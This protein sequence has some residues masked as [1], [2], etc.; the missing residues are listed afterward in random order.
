[1]LITKEH[2]DQITENYSKTHNT[3][4]VMGFVDGLIAMLEIIEDI[5]QKNK[6]V[7]NQKSK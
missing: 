1:M 6:Q 4:E 7:T 2:L 3:F 5:E